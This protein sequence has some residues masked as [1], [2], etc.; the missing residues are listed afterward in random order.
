MIVLRRRRQNNAL[1]LRG[2]MALGFL[3]LL[4]TAFAA[5]PPAPLPK[6]SPIQITPIPAAGPASSAPQAQQQEWV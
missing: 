4:S 2:L 3:T 1:P 5:D 6:A